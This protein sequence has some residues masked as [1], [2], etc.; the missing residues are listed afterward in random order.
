MVSLV[1]LGTVFK[2]PKISQMS[3]KISYFLKIGKS[4]WANENVIV[5]EV[6]KSMMEA[7][8]SSGL[9]KQE[10]PSN[11]Y[12]ETLQWL[13]ETGLVTDAFKIKRKVGL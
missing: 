1:T 12:V 5:D 6:K 13:P 3:I 10:M 11:V 8:K 2:R 9:G 7:A 4:E